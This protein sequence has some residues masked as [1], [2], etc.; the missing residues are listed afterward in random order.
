MGF[1]QG[2]VGVA[3]NLAVGALAAVDQDVADAAKPFLQGFDDLCGFAGDALAVEQLLVLC[4]F[5]NECV[6][7]AKST[8]GCKGDDGVDCQECDEDGNQH[9]GGAD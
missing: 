6:D 2:V 7:E 8:K 4:E 5:D 3:I 1:T 9:D